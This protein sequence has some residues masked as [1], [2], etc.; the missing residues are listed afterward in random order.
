[1]GNLTLERPTDNFNFPWLK[2]AVFLLYERVYRRALRRER[3]FRDHTNPLEVFDEEEIV[4]K[5]RFDRRNILKLTEEISEVIQHPKRRGSLPPL[6]QVCLSLRFF[7]TGSIQDVCGE[8]IKVSQPTASRT[9]KAVTEAL[10]ALAAQWIVFPD[11]GDAER[12]KEKFYQI[13]RFPNVFG[14]VDG[15]HVPLQAPAT[16][17]PEF[18]NR[19]NV[20]SLNVQVGYQYATCFSLIVK[21]YDCIIPLS[22]LRM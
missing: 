19:K 10:V 12:Q 13:A 16:N 11:R 4:A 6:L 3:V 5:F 14:C 20:Y 22:M 1:M 17:A 2:M 8:L 21:L 9:I 18:I 15:T 7:A